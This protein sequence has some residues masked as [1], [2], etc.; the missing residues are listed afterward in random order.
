MSSSESST[1]RWSRLLYYDAVLRDEI[2]AVDVVG[3][4]VIFCD[5]S[6]AVLD[7]VSETMVMEMSLQP[8]VA[9]VSVDEE[10][11]VLNYNDF[12]LPFLS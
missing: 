4:L 7:S 2:E 6:G 12:F 11:Q 3:D 10:A 5:D 8:V 1:S 9:V